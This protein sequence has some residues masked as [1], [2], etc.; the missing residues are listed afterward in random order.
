MDGNENLEEEYNKTLA[1]HIRSISAKLDNDQNDS[2]WYLSSSSEGE[3]D[4]SSF[5]KAMVQATQPQPSKLKSVITKVNNHK[6]TSLEVSRETSNVRF[7]NSISPPSRQRNRSRG[8]PR[9]AKVNR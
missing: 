5:S 3:G 4:S 8:R 2:S 7:E 6:P 1:E 9:G